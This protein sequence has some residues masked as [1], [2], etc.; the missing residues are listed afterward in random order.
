MITYT[1]RLPLVSIEKMLFSNARFLEVYQGSTEEVP[2]VRILT[3][4]TYGEL[5]VYYADLND[6]NYKPVAN[7]IP[8]FINH[9]TSHSEATIVRNSLVLNDCR[10]MI[11]D[12]LLVGEK[13][14]SEI[15]NA[16]VFE[17]ISYEILRMLLVKADL[18]IPE[19]DVKL[20]EIVHQGDGCYSFIFELG[21]VL[22]MKRTVVV[23]RNHKGDMRY[24]DSIHSMHDLG[25]MFKAL[26]YSGQCIKDLLEKSHPSRRVKYAPH[27]GKHDPVPVDPDVGINELPLKDSMFLCATQYVRTVTPKPDKVE[28]PQYEMT[29]LSEVSSRHD[30]SLNLP[31]DAQTEIDEMQ[32]LIKETVLKLQAFESRLETL[33]KQLKENTL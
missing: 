12:N 18:F 9:Y 29:S 26:N 14:M 23:C 7:F 4:Q 21:N 30:T 17:N 5:Y 3:F 19:R 27:E 16:S 24:V 1:N 33:K 32:T 6:S 10:K 31:V 15:L 2:I 11:L 22:K 25:F 13:K 20:A 28:P 8:E